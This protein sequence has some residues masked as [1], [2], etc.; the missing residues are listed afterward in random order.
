MTQVLVV[1]GTK[2]K[3]LLPGPDEPMNAGAEANPAIQI[4]DADAVYL[5]TCSDR[6]HDMGA[7]EDFAD[8]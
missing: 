7:I 4:V 3:V 5:I 8:R 2:R 6:T 1:N